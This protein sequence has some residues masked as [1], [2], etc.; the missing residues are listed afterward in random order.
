M[1]TLARSL[2]LVLKAEAR[3]T[4]P[5]LLVGILAVAL[6]LLH[7]PRLARAG[8]RWL[9]AWLILYWFLATPLGATAVATA[10]SWGFEP[11]R[12]RDEAQGAAAIVLL[13]GGIQSYFDDDSAL[14]DLEASAPRVLEAARVY[15]LLGGVPVIVSGG[16]TNE[17]NPPRPEGSAFK[18]AL[19]QLGV[20]PDRIRVDNQS[21]TTRE[22]SVR[23]K[24]MLESLGAGRFVLVTS[25]THMRR[26]MRVFE[27]AGMHPIPS[28][29]PLEA[30]TRHAALFPSR[31][32]LLLSDRAVYDAAALVY[33]Y[34][35]GWLHPAV[36]LVLA[37]PF[38]PS[39]RGATR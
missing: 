16:N 34:A 17:V 2:F 31:K 13:G 20:P 29:A 25:P 8:R 28:T 21:L 24:P 3:L 7:S 12:S 22:Q 19:V 18:A 6:A 33:Y 30:D 35:R 39:S 9:T 36:A 23:L 4:S 11:L 1:T 37:R 5:L 32:S 27:S 38:A 26:S 10:V 14:D 15:R